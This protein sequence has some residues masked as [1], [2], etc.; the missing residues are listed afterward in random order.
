MVIAMVIIE[1]IVSLALTLVVLFQ[2]GKE[3]GLSGALAG[4]TDT[5]MSK[6]KGATLDQKLASLTKW[7]ALAWVLVTLVLVLVIA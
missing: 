2:S 6:N 1:I 4:G 5:Y 3:S 7:I